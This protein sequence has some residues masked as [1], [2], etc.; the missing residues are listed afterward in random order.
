M[1]LDRQTGDLHVRQNQWTSRMAEPFAKPITVS[2]SD[3][4]RFA[5]PI[6]RATVTREAYSITASAWL[7]NGR[8][9]RLA[10]VDQPLRKSASRA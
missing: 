3:G 5:P 9:T 1:G 7:S 2:E 10:T 4:Y 8:E 6:L